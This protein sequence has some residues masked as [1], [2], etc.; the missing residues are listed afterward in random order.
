MTPLFHPKLVNG[1][2]DDPALYIEFL[3]E[4]RAILFDLGDLHALAPR[5]LLRVSHIFVSHAHMDHF[6]GFDRL[7]R[8]CLG[9]GKSL[10]FFGPAGFI[11]RVDSKLK[12]YSWNLVHN[13]E[14]DLTLT[15]TEIHAGNQIRTAEFHLLEAFHCKDLGSSLIPSGAPV[16]EEGLR[17]NAEILDH[18]IPCLAFA[19]EEKQHINIWKNRLNEI[20][21]RVGP[22]LRELKQA[23]LREDPDDTV[24]YARW[25]EGN[26][27]FERKFSLGEL[28]SKILRIVPGQ[29]IGYVADAI[30]QQDNVDK[31]VDLV[32]SADI[33]FIESAFMDKDAEIAANKK[34]L[35]AAQAGR[36][37]R[38]A[39]VKRV[40]PFHFSPRYSR[41]PQ[42]LAREV[43]HAFRSKAYLGDVRE[44]RE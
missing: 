19:L 23:V 7:V 30:F 15:V 5:K 20:G 28:K 25:H 6:V 14:I 29:K 42:S 10:H 39:G 16:E 43:E 17:I 31:I 41:Q 11:D 33:L 12:G 2:F 21:L 35:T 24:F 34:H 4:K 26:K 38:E 1:P 9:R 36:I 27:F 13:Y 3:F 40:V 44:V 18:D 8:V 32:K 22:W 37:A